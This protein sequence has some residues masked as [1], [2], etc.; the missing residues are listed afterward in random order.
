GPAAATGRTCRG[1][2]RRFGT[3]WPNWSACGAS[4]GRILFSG[5]SGPTRWPTGGSMTPP[6]GCY[7][8]P[9]TVCLP[10]GEGE[11]PTRMETARRGPGSDRALTRTCLRTRAPVTTL[12]ILGGQHLPQDDA[13]RSH[14]RAV[15]PAL[16]A[17]QVE[18]SVDA[19]SD[20]RQHGQGARGTLRLHRQP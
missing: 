14:R 11:R 17:H 13:E 18:R 20:D 2:S 7:L 8:G 16:A 15:A 1:C 9:L 6:P 19:Q 5:R 10:R 12:P 4:T 3:P